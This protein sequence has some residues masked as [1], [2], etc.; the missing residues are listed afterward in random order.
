M[1]IKASEIT[2]LLKKQIEGFEGGADVAEVGTVIQVGDGSAV[3]HGLSRTPS[4]PCCWVR[5]AR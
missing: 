2:S 5:T 4:A 1:Q 3:L